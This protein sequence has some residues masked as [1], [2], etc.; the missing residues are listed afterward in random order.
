MAGGS[1]VQMC[2]GLGD[3]GPGGERILCPR[4]L[5]LWWMVTDLTID[6][7]GRFSASSTIAGRTMSVSTSGMPGILSARTWSPQALVLETF[8][9]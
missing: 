3:T 5:R 9:L 4:I 1:L 8:V 7:L 6:L 2:P